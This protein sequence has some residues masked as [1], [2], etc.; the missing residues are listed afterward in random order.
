MFELRVTPGGNRPIYRQII[1][2][3]RQAVATGELAVGDALPSVRQLAEELVLNHNTV[4]KAYAELV[5]EGVLDSRHGRG[6]FVA[7]RRRVYSAGERKRRLDQ[8]LNVFLSEAL[9]LDYT[10]QQI[11]EAVTNWLDQMTTSKAKDSEVD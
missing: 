8:A 7:K 1:D 9:T 10:P 3:V 11:E 2:Q 6:V 4:A 5:R